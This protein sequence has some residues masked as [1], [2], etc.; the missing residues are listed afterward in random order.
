MEKAETV[1]EYSLSMEKSSDVSCR[2]P[3]RF[4][5]NIYYI[6]YILFIPEL[7]ILPISRCDQLKF[8]KMNTFIEFIFQQ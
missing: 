2:F 1:H 5:L 8:G 6:V 4:I 7:F 3:S